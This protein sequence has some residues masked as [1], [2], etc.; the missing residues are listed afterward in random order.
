[1][2]MNQILL[3]VLVLLQMA[4]LHSTRKKGSFRVQK[5]NKAQSRNGKLQEGTQSQLKDKLKS[6]GILWDVYVI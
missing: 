4:H 1:M 2:K 6:K 5:V 3:I